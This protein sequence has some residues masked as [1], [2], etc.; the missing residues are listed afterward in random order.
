MGRLDLARSRGPRATATAP[1]TCPA[2]IRQRLFARRPTRLRRLPVPLA[3]RYPG[4]RADKGIDRHGR[5]MTA[6]IF[7]LVGVVVGGLLQILA[8]QL[9]TLGQRR[10]DRQRKQLLRE[11]LS[12]YQWRSFDQCKKVIGADDETTRRLLIEVGARGSEAEADSWGLISKNPFQSPSS[13]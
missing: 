11:M 6:A 5:V 7:G 8:Q 13:R 3:S 10:I 12:K 4:K 2:P 9:A 1:A